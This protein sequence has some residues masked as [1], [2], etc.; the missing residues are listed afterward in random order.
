LLKRN[1]SLKEKKLERIG[2]LYPIDL[3]KDS[4]GHYKN[5]SSKEKKE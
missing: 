1:S 4:K 3:M 5:R 2:R